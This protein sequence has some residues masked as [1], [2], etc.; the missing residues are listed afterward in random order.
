MYPLEQRTYEFSKNIISLCKKIKIDQLNRNVVD[1]LLRSSTSIGANYREA[2]GAT[3]RLDFRNKIH[4]C[5]KESHETHYWLS[6]LSEVCEH[7]NNPQ[8]SQLAKEAE[9]LTLIF[10]KIVSSLKNSKEKFNIHK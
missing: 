7:S 8:L 4:I 9:E 6:L 1:Q 10:G 2:N 3:S 5:K